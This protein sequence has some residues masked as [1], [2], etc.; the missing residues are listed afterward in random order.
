MRKKKNKEAQKKRGTM[1]NVRYWLKILYRD[2]PVYVWL[3]LAGILLNIGS[4]LLGV[5]MPSVLVADVTNGGTVEKV[6]TDVAL[7]GGVLMCL[8]LLGSLLGLAKELSDSRIRYKQ[9][10]RIAAKSIEADYSKIERADFP[11]DFWELTNRHMWRNEY[12]AKFME[13]IVSFVTA[14]I[15]M[16][17]YTGMLS[18]LSLWLLLLVAAGSA[19]NYFVGVRCNKWDGDNCHKWHDLDNK[20]FYLSRSTSSYEASKDVH[21]YGMPPWLRK[22]FDRELKQRLKYTVRQQAN[23][24]AEGAVRGITQ[25][26]WEGAAYLYLIGL[27]CGGSLDAAGFVLYFGIIG[28]F[29][30]WCTSIAEGMRQLHWRAVLVEEERK[31]LERLEKDCPGEKEELAMEE[32]HIPEISFVNVSFRYGDSE[33]DVI[34]NLNLTI[35]PGEKIALVGRNGAGKSTLIKLLCGFYDPTEGEIRIDGVNRCRYSRESWLRCLSGVFQDAG[36]FPLSL[37]ENLELGIKADSDRIMECLRLAGLEEKLEKLPKGL[38]TMFGRESYEDA[39][40][41]S[42]GELQ[43]LMLARALC[44][45]APLLVLDEPTAALDPLMESELY[46]KFRELAEHKT[47]VF[48]SHRL[49]STRFCDKILLMEEGGIVESGTHGELMERKGKYAE[50]FRIQSRY[51]QKKQE[52][53]EAGLEGEVVSV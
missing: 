5:Y 11:G 39:V 18:E 26:I 19:V 34:K 43:K 7:L 6:L 47:A 49:A 44:K 14:V 13:A 4:S 30:S 35:K 16:V 10:L 50:M 45:Q 25:M 51:Y 42:G 3:Y 27:V 29:S 48:I 46:E 15:G 53:K 20:M 21:L 2:S 24:Y 40:D 41:F 36:L 8:K 32:G 12:T 38:D 28:G 31:F 33:K 23:F 9:G 1:E 17:L 37:R 22:L 52:Q